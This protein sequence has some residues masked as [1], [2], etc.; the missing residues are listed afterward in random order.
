MTAARLSTTPSQPPRLWG[1]WVCGLVVDRT[2]IVS[3]Q[4]SLCHPLGVAL[5]C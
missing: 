1:V 5:L 4:V 2:V 3:I